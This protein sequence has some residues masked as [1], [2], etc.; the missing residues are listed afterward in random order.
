[1]KIL[2]SRQPHTVEWWRWMSEALGKG[3]LFRQYFSVAV[4][5]G[6]NCQGVVSKGATVREVTVFQKLPA[7]GG[8]A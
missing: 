3:V 4:F 5:S 7:A 6:T 2:L 1:M 8:H